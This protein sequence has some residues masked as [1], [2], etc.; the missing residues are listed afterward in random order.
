MRKSARGGSRSAQPGTNYSNRTDMQT[1]PVRTAPSTQYG[2]GVQQEAAQQAIPL[3]QAQPPSAP[4]QQAAPANY[5]GPT[6]GS[7]GPLDRG[8]DRPG[9]HVSTGLKVGPG[10]GPEVL[11]PYAG[12]DTSARLR[13]LYAQF[14]NQDLAE[15]IQVADA[16]R[17]R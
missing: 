10:A 4:A 17:G 7:L 16:N 3:P 6:P 14:P 8:T 11:G 13:S 2:Q 9:E 5:Q 1:Q 12:D 15:L